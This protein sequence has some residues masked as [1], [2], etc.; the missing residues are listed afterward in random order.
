M[1]NLNFF[2][3][4]PPINAAAITPKNARPHTLGQA[5]AGNMV[6]ISGFG[7]L[8]SVHKQHLQ[9]YGLFPG[10]TVQVLAQSPVTI[11]MVEQTELAF[12]TEIAEQVTIE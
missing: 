6:T 3:S 7:K 10:R 5:K 4:T 11:I 12:E 2:R 9:A 8:S 1:L